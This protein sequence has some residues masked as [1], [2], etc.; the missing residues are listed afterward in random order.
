MTFL[1]CLCCRS[2]RFCGG[3]LRVVSGLLFFYFW[4]TFLFAWIEDL[5][6]DCAL[7]LVLLLFV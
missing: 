2:H 4:A 7:L 3:Y 5:K 1:G 6:C